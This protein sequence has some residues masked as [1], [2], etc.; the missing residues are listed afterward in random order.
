MFLI[1]RIACRSVAGAAWAFLAATIVEAAPIVIA[2]RGASGYLP[3]HTLVAKALAHG[4]GADFIEQDIVLTKDNV[5]IV[6]HDIQLDTVSDVAEVFPGRAREDGRFYAID[7]TLDEVRRLR[8]CER[9]D[10]RTGRQAYPERFPTTTDAALRISTFEEELDFLAGLNRST[11]RRTGVYPEIKEPAW[12]RRE[13]HDLSPLVLAA[14]RRHGFA[15]RSDRC[16]VQCFDADEVRRIRHELRWE[17]G[18]VQLLEDAPKDAPVDPTESGH[19]SAV[20]STWTGGRRGSLQRPMPWVSSCIP[21]P[22]ASISSPPSPGRPKRHC[23]GYSPRRQLTDSLPTFLMSACGGFRNTRPYHGLE[24]RGQRTMRL[25]R[26]T[27]LRSVAAFAATAKDKDSPV[28][29]TSAP[30]FRL[31]SDS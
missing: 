16:F 18:L 7:F 11:G 21:T 12:H 23:R 30:V 3:E 2:H 24:P 31:T 28:N 19:R 29:G 10:P 26:R 1:R 4:Q 13:G 6:V 27:M 22:F 15:T 14:L 8:V 25:T 5:P 17:G 20:C 9:R